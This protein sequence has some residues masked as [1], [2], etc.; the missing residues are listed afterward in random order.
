M[1]E[2]K[3]DYYVDLEDGDK[4]KL[5]FN[6]RQA[7]YSIASRNSKYKYT[8]DE[9][10]QWARKFTNGEQVDAIKAGFSLERAL[11]FEEG[12]DVWKFSNSLISA[13]N[14]RKDQISFE[15]LSLLN[16]ACKSS[17]SISFAFAILDMSKDKTLSQV[18]SLMQKVE[19]SSNRVDGVHQGLMSVLKHSNFQTAELFADHEDCLHQ[20]NAATDSAFIENLIVTCIGANS[21]L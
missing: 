13:Y 5:D 12:Q 2:Q 1:S 16:S 4:K 14:V 17:K 20:A 6:Q 18:I 7:F 11:E 15:D 19:N 21:E 10:M 9:V 8:Y 3:N